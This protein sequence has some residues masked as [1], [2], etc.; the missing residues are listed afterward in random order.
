MSKIFSYLD[1]RNIKIAIASQNSD[2]DLYANLRNLDAS[3]LTSDDRCNRAMWYI[4]VTTARG[5]VNLTDLLSYD[6]IYDT[7][8][9]PLFI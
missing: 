2:R 8:Y 6:E 1:D 9:I 7:R 4:M 5:H 3:N